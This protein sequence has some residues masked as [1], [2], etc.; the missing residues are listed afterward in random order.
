LFVLVRR[1][2][3]WLRWNQSPAGARVFTARWSFNS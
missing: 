2:W 1:G 3:R